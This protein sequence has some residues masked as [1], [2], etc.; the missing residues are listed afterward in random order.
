MQRCQGQR[1][2]QPLRRDRTHKTL[3]SVHGDGADGVL[4]EVLRDLEDETTSGE[5]LNLK[6]VEDG[7]KVLDRGE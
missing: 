3:G 4:A 1:M 7:R 6:G 2:R 5:A